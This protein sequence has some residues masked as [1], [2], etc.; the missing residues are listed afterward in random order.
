LPVLEVL[1]HILISVLTVLGTPFS[2]ADL[3]R[4]ASRMTAKFLRFPRIAFA[5]SELVV[6]SLSVALGLWVH[7]VGR[8]G[9]SLEDW[10]DVE[11]NQYFEISAE[12]WPLQ[13]VDVASRF[14]SDGGR[15]LAAAG[16]E[17]GIACA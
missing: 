8:L 10:A 1:C 17:A 13:I 14:D 6:A 9:T 16:V 11:T 4:L 15:K 3:R 2:T 5:L 12:Y 7:L